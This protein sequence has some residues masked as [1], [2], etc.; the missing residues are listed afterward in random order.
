MKQSYKIHVLCFFIALGLF[1]NLIQAQLSWAPAQ[2]TNVEEVVARGVLVPIPIP[3]KLS[4]LR[5][6]FLQ[7]DG[8]VV[9]I[10]NDHQKP[11]NEEGRAGIFKFGSNGEV[12]TIT[13]IGEA[14]VNSSAKV[15]GVY[16]LKVEGGRAVFSV[17]LENGGE[18]IA[19]WENSKVYLLTATGGTEGLSDFGN[20]DLSKDI[21]VFS[22]KS[23]DSGRSLYAVN[24]QNA[25]RTPVAIVPNGLAIPGQA[26]LTFQKFASSQFADGKEA[27][28]RAYANENTSEDSGAKYAGVFR[29][30]A[31]QTDA[32]KKIVD[33]NTPIPGATQGMTFGQ[34]QHSAIPADG[35]TIIVNKTRKL[36]G[37]YRAAPDGK[38]DRLVDTTTTI[39]DLFDGPFTGFNKWV[40]NTPPWVLFVA[41]A[42]N[43]FGIFAINWDTQELYLL[44]DSR[45]AFDG[46]KIK[47]AEISNTAKVN[48]HVALMLMFEDG[49]SGIYVAT[50][51]KGLAMKSSGGPMN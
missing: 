23:K 12:T 28:F 49:S 9:F 39:P 32:P 19:L 38:V 33:S 46:K 8:S 36:E 43:Y 42:A 35:I 13:T 18:G 45:M 48:N 25:D 34:Y 27:V 17:M 6:P 30:S 4:N 37:I 16:A 10:A 51:E 22:A 40:C 15:K 2:L 3:T 14:F 31:F 44:A 7:E 29:V 41:K 11:K 50:F 26:G 1:P 24:L 21:V 5:Y 47:D 20:P